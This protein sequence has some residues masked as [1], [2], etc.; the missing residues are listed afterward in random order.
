[1]I[2]PASKKEL[3]IE[4][5]VQK[6]AAEFLFKLSLSVNGRFSPVSTLYWM[7]EKSA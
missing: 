6:V 2:L 5:I 3:L 4:E 1:M 7:Q